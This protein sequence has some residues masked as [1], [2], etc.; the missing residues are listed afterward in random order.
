MVRA[1]RS[2]GPLRDSDDHV[3]DV[4]ANL[5][6]KLG[7]DDGRAF[8]LYVVWKRRH[9]E[10]TFLD[11]LRIV[12]KNA[13]RDHVRRQSG[14]GLDPVAARDPE[15]RRLLRDFV[16][17]PAIDEL[18]QRPPMTEAQTAQE[19]LRYADLNLP[20]EQSRALRQWLEGA[21]FDEIV[22]DGGAG[23]APAAQRLVRAALATLRRRFGSE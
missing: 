2:L 3:H 1:Q 21:T 7:A 14:A 13:A 9:P 8:G 23:G 11:W 12:T 19:L 15:V 17:S 4:L 6:E 18:G 5:V 10:K 20:L 16:T 22:S